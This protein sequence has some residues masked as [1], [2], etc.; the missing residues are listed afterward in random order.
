M[1]LTYRQFE[2]GAGIFEVFECADLEELVVAY[3]VSI[4]ESQGEEPIFFKK[5]TKRSTLKSVPG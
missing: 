2:K 3:A 1:Q 5:S 4:L